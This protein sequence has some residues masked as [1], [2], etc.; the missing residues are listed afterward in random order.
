MRVLWLAPWFRSLA[1][2]YGRGLT[3]EGHEVQVITSSKHPQPAPSLVEELVCPKKPYDPRWAH[4]LVDAE[5]IYRRFRPHVVIADEVTDPVFTILV[6]RMD[7][8]WLVIHDALPHDQ[9]HELHGLRKAIRA[10]EWRRPSHILTFSEHVAG[11]LQAAKWDR[12]SAQVHRVNLLS[13]VRDEDVP[14]LRPSKER[15]DFVLMGRVAP[16]KNI[17]HVLRASDARPHSPHFRGDRLIIWGAGQWHRT[18][19][20]GVD[21]KDNDSVKWR[22]EV[23][24]YS[25]IRNGRFSGF[26]AAFAFTQ[27]PRKVAYRY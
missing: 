25:D 22:P 27:K 24:R 2:I 10:A 5:R 26:R 18:Q 4:A 13:D 12:H 23:Y 14:S 3:V 16:Y 20:P 17:N 11:E 9:T 7:P 1:N 15:R 21:A 19:S 6:Q 8:Q